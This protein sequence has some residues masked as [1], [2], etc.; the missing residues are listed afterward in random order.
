MDD[1]ILMG[2]AHRG[3]YALEEPEPCDDVE[4]VPI[5][6]LVDRFPFD[7]LHDQERQAVLGRAAIENPRDVGMIEPCQDLALALEAPGHFL[8]VEPAL[9]DLDG[10]L[11]F[12]GLVGT[13][14]QIHP[15]HPTAAEFAH[16]AIRAD[17][18]PLEHSCAA[19][20]EHLERLYECG[21]PREVELP[22]LVRGQQRIDFATQLKVV[23]A[24]GIEP[25][26]AAVRLTVERGLKDLLE[27][28]PA[29]RLHGG[30]RK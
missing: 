22:L 21:G 10:D 19:L 16:H 7:V 12:E 13:R 15:A 3:A 26:R 6:V 5:A 29:L 24:G 30:T 23:T 25:G 27:L 14:G 28:P 11:L 4:R 1:Q 9:D 18:P 2:V 17:A 8:A 20:L